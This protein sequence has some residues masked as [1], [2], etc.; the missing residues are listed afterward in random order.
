M[1]TVTNPYTFNIKS[2]CKF[3]TNTLIRNRV[4][5]TM[6]YETS[7]ESED[8]GE[9]YTT[10]ALYY[11]YNNTGSMTPNII[12]GN[13][14]NVVSINHSD[15]HDND[16]FGVDVA[17]YSSTKYSKVILNGGPFKNCSIPY[18]FSAPSDSNSIYYSKSFS[19][20]SSEID[21]F[22]TLR[23]YDNVPFDLTIEFV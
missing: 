23:K 10:S 12:N 11:N 14:I 8:H 16:T 22:W 19:N 1:S 4:K 6:R 20:P 18:D 21:D 17:V 9:S 13:T 2:N 15:K 5:I 3:S 7:T